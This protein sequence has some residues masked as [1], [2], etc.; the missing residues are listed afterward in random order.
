M[1]RRQ[2][3]LALPPLSLDERLAAGRT[4]LRHVLD[5]QRQ[6]QEMAE[7][8]S[9]RTHESREGQRLREQNVLLLE[10]IAATL[11]ARPKGYA[12]NGD[13]RSVCRDYPEC[14]NHAGCEALQDQQAAT[15]DLLE[16]L[17]AGDAAV[18]SLLAGADRA[19]ERLQ[20]RRGAA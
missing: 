3:D 9:S 8:R 15:L 13:E 18:R 4:L 5:R 17:A 6:M 19:L 10:G 2:M 14:S 20:R 7:R 16:H 12:R 11:N 1:D